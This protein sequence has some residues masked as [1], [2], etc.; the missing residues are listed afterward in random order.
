MLIRV[1][2]VLRGAL[3]EHLELP[4]R[5]NDE[6]LSIGSWATSLDRSASVPRNKYKHRII[7]VQHASDLLSTPF[8][9]VDAAIELPSESLMPACN[10][11]FL[12]LFMIGLYLVWRNGF[13]Q[14][15]AWPCTWY[16]RTHYSKYANNV[17]SL[18]RNDWNRERLKALS[19][20]VRDSA[21]TLCDWC[22][23]LNVRI[24][25]LAVLFFLPE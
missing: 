7:R 2:K 21:T 10:F 12:A 17:T 8:P 23:T 9:S 1:Q 4:L 3:D 22:K 5:I 20:E 18:N 24:A 6:D 13:Q 19:V 14:V 16:Y 25:Q 15:L 11:A